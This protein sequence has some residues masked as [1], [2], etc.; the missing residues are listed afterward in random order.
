[1][2]FPVSSETPKSLPRLIVM[3]I[4]AYVP[5]YRRNLRVA[6]PVMLTQL[7]AAL[8]GLF[9]SIMVGHYGTTDLAAVSFSNA[10]FFTVMVFAMGV[11]M[12][13]T[14]LVGQE[15]GRREKH[16]E[17]IADAGVERGRDTCIPKEAEQNPEWEKVQECEERI[18]GLLRN[19]VWLTILLS[20]IMGVLLGCCIPALDLF[21]QEPSVTKTAEPYFTLIVISLVPFLFFC[22][23]KQFLEGLG[24]TTAAMLITF[25][26]NGLNIFLN[27]VF[28]FGHLDFEPMGAKGAGIATLISRT[29]MP[30]VFLTVM[31]C[32]QEWRKYLISRNR[33][34]RIPG[35]AT[36]GEL[37]E[38]GLPIG[39]QTLLETIAFTASFIMVGWLSKEALAA[40]QIANQIAD[41][42][43][44]VALGIGA[45]TTIR[46]SHQYGKGDM[47]AVKMASHASVHLVLLMNTIGAGLMIGL[48]HY[49]PYLFTE[50]EAVVAIASQL[51][52]C[53][54]LLQYADGLQ[55]VGA[56]MLRGITD[57]KR[58][59]VYAFVAYILVALPIGIVCM[60]PLQMGAVGIWIGFIFGLATAAVLF[61]IR[62][63]RLTN[64]YTQYDTTTA[65]R[66]DD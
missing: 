21:G 35:T 43:F 66:E 54:G 15:V 5:Y 49:I 65:C 48:R 12:G 39:G 58:P 50:D 64:H 32:K 41:M 61:H 52:L 57:V 51:I 17:R 13:V 1:M 10:I 46:V 2:G 44:M 31:V 23:E 47:H 56:A 63:R 60:F 55:C 33:D 14:P 53:A 59:M 11:L 28:I 8:V 45:A 3:G 30:F 4:K 38:V 19:G 37:L 9:D 16:F 26:M 7:G 18:A 34:T 27:W 62:F 40:H 22:L 42:T 25:G 20:I 36:I 24:N 29:I 6:L